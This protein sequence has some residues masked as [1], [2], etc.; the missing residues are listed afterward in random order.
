MQYSFDAM[1]AIQVVVATLF[2]VM[3]IG[4]P[5]YFICKLCNTAEKV[6]KKLDSPKAKSA[7]KGLFA[8]GYGYW[9]LKKAQVAKTKNE[10]SAFLSLV[11]EAKGLAYEANEELEGKKSG[12]FY[13][14]T[15]WWKKSDDQD[16]PT[17]PRWNN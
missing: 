4:L 7:I 15:D 5:V 8:L 17:S 9:A 2:F 1:Y 16:P 6:I 12:K 11:D 13:D 3:I 10:Q 14:D